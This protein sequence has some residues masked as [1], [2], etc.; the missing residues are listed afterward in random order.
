MS[1]S[2]ETPYILNS[3]RYKVTTETV[4]QATPMFKAPNHVE[5]RNVLWVLSNWNRFLLQKAV[6]WDI[7]E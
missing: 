7:C 6:F 1:T 4:P 2:R 5:H 3:G